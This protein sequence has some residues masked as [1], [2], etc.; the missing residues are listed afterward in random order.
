MGMVDW[1]IVQTSRDTG[2]EN[3][4]LEGLDFADDLALLE[5]PRSDKQQILDYLVRHGSQIGLK[6]S[7]KR[8]KLMAIYTNEDGYFILRQRKGAWKSVWIHIL[9][10]FDY[11]PQISSDYVPFPQQL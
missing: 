2:I 6:I 11:E 10:K 8:T 9:R 3:S 4:Q 1:L 7:A 5:G